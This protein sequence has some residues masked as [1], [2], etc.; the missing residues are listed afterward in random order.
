MR[1]GNL[2]KGRAENERDM[3]WWR[4]NRVQQRRATAACV[5]SD[6]QSSA[7]VFCKKINHKTSENKITVAMALKRDQCVTRGGRSG[8]GNKLEKVGIP[9]LEVRWTDGGR[10][11][12][13]E[14]DQLM[15]KLMGQEVQ[16]HGE[17]LARVHDG[18]GYR[19]RRWGNGGRE[20]FEF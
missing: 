13:S 4:M 10:T 3:Q 18:E 20:G 19:C 6:L 1:R 12:D 5:A 14:L 2:T 11:R 16:Q 15:A 8:K 9:I 7:R 17:S